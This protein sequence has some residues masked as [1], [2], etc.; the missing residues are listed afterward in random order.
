MND[1][2]CEAQGQMSQGG[3]EFLGIFWRVN[4]VVGE[5]LLDA[6]AGLRRLQDSAIVADRMRD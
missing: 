1:V 6:P 3:C 2:W 5:R 4:L